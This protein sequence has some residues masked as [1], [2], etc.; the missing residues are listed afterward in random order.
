MTAGLNKIEVR[1]ARPAAGT[2]AVVLRY[3]WMAELTCSP[4]CRV[5]RE[6]VEGDS[7]GFVKIVGEPLP[8]EFVVTLDYAAGG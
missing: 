5:E 6:V 1:D 4:G 7:A 3:H 2:Q 8:R